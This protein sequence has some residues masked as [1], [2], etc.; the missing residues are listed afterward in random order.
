M[1]TLGDKLF[2]RECSHGL[3]SNML[4]WGPKSRVN[5]EA[6]VHG[7]HKPYS[8]DFGEAY[9]RVVKEKVNDKLG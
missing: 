7:Y 3:F 4:Y 2:G 1:A 9:E 8:K 6:K 5:D